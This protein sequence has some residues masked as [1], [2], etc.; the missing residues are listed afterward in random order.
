MFDSIPSDFSGLSIFWDENQYEPKGAL[1][2]LNF[3]H[4]KSELSFA[5]S[6]S[7]NYREGLIDILVQYKVEDCIVYE[8][9][10]L[11]YNYIDL[12]DYIS[13]KTFLLYRYENLNQEDLVEKNIGIHI[14]FPKNNNLS[15]KV[16]EISVKRYTIFKAKAS[17]NLSLTPKNIE[18][19][20]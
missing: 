14:Q 8:E 15:F 18:K 3:N 7:F 1:R 4:Q 16:K 10:D 13:I 5:P 17:R 9:S 20:Y 2:L 19:I 12:Y 6:N 11:G